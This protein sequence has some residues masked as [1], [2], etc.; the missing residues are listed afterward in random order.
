MLLFHVIRLHVAFLGLSLYFSCIRFLVFKFFQNR[1]EC[2][3]RPKGG[4]GPS[5]PC[6][7]E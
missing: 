1:K 4:G 7:G 5:F 3:T 2:L 6:S